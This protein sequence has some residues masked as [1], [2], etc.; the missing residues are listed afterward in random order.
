MVKGCGIEK[1]F[2]HPRPCAPWP[3]RYRRS[4]RPAPVDKLLLYL[5]FRSLVVFY[6]A[7]CGVSL[8]VGLP[9]SK[10]TSE[11]LSTSISRMGEKKYPAMLAPAQI[12]S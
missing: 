5:A 12:F 7:F 10:W 3:G 2:H 6:A 11:V 4:L 9:T 1:N 8:S